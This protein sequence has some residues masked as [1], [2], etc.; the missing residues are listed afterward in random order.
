MDS[1]IDKEELRS[2]RSDSTFR[3]LCSI[4]KVSVREPKARKKLM[5]FGALASYG[6]VILTQFLVACASD[7]TVVAPPP[8]VHGASFVGD[9]SCATCHASIANKIAGSAHFRVHA[10]KVPDGQSTSC[11]SCHG[12][13]SLHVESGGGTPFK[14]QI[15]NPGK[16]AEACLKCHVGE[17]AEFQLPSRH[18]V[19]EKKMNCV[20]C[21]DPHGHDIMKP[22]G[23]FGFAR[24]NQSCAECHQEQSRNFVF[25]HEAVGEG[26]TTCH[27]AHGS[28]NDKLLV[29]PDSNLCLKC[30]AQVPGGSDGVVIGKVDHSLFVQQGSCTSCHTAI[31]GSN[32]H[33]K[34]L[35]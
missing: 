12:P 5:M 27:Q 20:D 8:E 35:Y 19:L 1:G 31:H 32:I 3:Q 29:Q 25:E 16:S 24:V 10:G 4:L 26:C 2:G 15:V 13:G 6:V 34:L 9:G 11:E 22:A 21:H 18:P 33:P 28:V 30:H 7:R 23:G 17:H 14:R